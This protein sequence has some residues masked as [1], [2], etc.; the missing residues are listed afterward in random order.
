[1]DYDTCENS[2]EKKE[3]RQFTG[4]VRNKSCLKMFF[5]KLCLA[6]Q[7]EIKNSI[8]NPLAIGQN[9]IVRYLRHHLREVKKILM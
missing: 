1:M 7:E 5:T 4:E 3:Q 2:L 8:T 9:S 6:F